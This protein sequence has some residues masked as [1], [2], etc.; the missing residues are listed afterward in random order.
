MWRY[1]SIFLWCLS[2][3]AHRSPTTT[4]I[5]KLPCK[6][7]LHSSHQTKG[8]IYKGKRELLLHKGDTLELTD[9][10][11]QCSYFSDIIPE[12]CIKKIIIEPFIKKLPHQVTGVR[13]MNELPCAL[14]VTIRSENNCHSFICG[15]VLSENDHCTPTWIDIPFH[16]EK[17][18]IRD[19]RRKHHIATLSSELN[20]SII[21][22]SQRLSI[23]S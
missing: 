10:H 13:I 6:L 21:Y 23:N 9:V 7:Y 8:I 12:D 15:P 17:L 22:V 4:V 20:N 14:L 16:V 3:A 5:S 11:L 18:E 1:Y 19:A 2:I